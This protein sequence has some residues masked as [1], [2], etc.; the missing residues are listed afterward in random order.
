MRIK[1]WLGL[2][3][4]SVFSLLNPGWRQ[5]RRKN[6]VSLWLE[7]S[8]KKAV[9]DFRQKAVACSVN[10]LINKHGGI[11]LKTKRQ[12]QIS[13][14]QKDCGV[15]KCL[16]APSPRRGIEPRSPA[17]QAG[18]L[19]TILTRS[20]CFRFAQVLL[21]GKEWS[22]TFCLPSASVKTVTLVLSLF[23]LSILG[24]LDSFRQWKEEMV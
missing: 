20:C 11:Q 19:T 3:S 12:N 13:T 8:Q 18:I 9:K 14:K 5:A 6:Y 1:R 2:A 24:T 16:K 7:F 10:A 22:L 21:Q 17:W 15:K 23:M 4:L